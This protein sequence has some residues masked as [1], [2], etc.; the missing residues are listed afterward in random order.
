MCK[1]IIVNDTINEIKIFLQIMPSRKRCQK[2]SSHSSP[3]LFQNSSD[4]EVSAASEASEN[5]I[6]S[7]DSQEVQYTH[8]NLIVKFGFVMKYQMN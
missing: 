3:D 1:I 6:P 4:S 5:A 7:Q 8:L 2:M